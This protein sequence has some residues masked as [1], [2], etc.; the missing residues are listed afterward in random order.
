MPHMFVSRPRLYDLTKGNK[1]LKRQFRWETINAV[2]Y[3]V[4]GF[5]FI[6]GSIFFFP[7]S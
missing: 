6:I 3:K 5:L 4:G 2:I 1:D 7:K